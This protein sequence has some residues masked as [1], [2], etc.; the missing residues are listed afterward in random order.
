VS[1]S[2]P[3]VTDT[4][5]LIHLAEA[6]ALGLLDQFG[7]VL[8]PHTVDEELRAG[9]VPEAFASV[10]F[11]R[12]TVDTDDRWPELDP[13]ESAALA[14]TERAGGMILTDD[15]AARKRANEFGIEVHGSIGVVLT[16]Y[17]DGRLDADEA[18]D[19]VR[20]LEHESTLYLSKPLVNR[21]M[22]RIEEDAS[23]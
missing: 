8:V 1:G 9:G 5:P 6:D 17:A 19:S 21:A 2:R 14:L 22:R 11:E 3:V 18:I 7:T 4:G 10:D 20:A 12:R 15:M 13:G 23:E 16:A